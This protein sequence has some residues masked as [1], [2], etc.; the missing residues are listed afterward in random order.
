[1]AR[2]ALTRS[3]TDRI[4]AGVCGG[5]AEHFGVDSKLVRILWVAAVV[6]GGF[7]ALA[8]VIMWIVIPE[9]ERGT[10]AE[11]IVEERFARGEIDA[12]EMRRLKGDLR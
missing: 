9:S 8:Y 5:L 6:F 12:D 10:P 1:M 3:T 7:G 11:R 4:F 2:G